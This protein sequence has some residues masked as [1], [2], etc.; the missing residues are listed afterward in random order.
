MQT[1]TQH[2]ESADVTGKM[3][4]IV[5]DGSSE[6]SGELRLFERILARLEQELDGA[7]PEVLAAAVDR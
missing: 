6:L 5:D 4:A 7:D 1:D 3:R 2:Y